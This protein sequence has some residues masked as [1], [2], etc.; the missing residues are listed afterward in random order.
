MGE[1]AEVLKP[2]GDIFLNLMFT[3]VIPLVFFSVTSAIANMDSAGRFK[4]VMSST[5]FRIF[6]NRLNSCFGDGRSG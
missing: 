2:F 5:F 4:K 3:L 1:K 6:R